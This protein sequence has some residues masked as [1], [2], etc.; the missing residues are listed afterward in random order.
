MNFHR[1]ILEGN[2]NQKL[3]QIF[4]TMLTHKQKESKYRSSLLITLQ[5]YSLN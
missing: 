4:F 5:N 2:C 3:D 1:L